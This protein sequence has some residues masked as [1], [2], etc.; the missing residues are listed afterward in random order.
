MSSLLRAVCAPNLFNIGSNPMA[1][2]PPQVTR[3][4]LAEILEAQSASPDVASLL[5]ALQRTLE[6]EK[7]LT[8]MFSADAASAPSASLGGDDG[9]SEDEPTPSASKNRSSVAAELRKKVRVG[10]GTP[11]AP[12][13]VR[14]SFL[15]PTRDALRQFARHAAVRVALSTLFALS[16]SLPPFALACPLPPN[17]RQYEAQRSSAA[18]AQAAAAAATSSLDDEDGAAAAGKPPLGPPLFSAFP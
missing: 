13:L 15:S 6:F 14:V 1:T 8:D 11:R 12:G 16:T 5:A 10:T 2:L 4:A 3:S 17:R 18:A 9:A 7:E